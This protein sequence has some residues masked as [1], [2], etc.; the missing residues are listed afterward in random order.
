MSRVIVLN[1]VINFEPEK[2]NFNSRDA[3]VH[4]SAPAAYCFLLLIEKQGELVTHEELYQ[5]AW[6]QFGMEATA[7]TL[8][9]NI[10]VIR[11]GLEKCGLQE[12]IIRT[13][14]R[15]GFIL[16][17]AV[18]VQH[19]RT[20]DLHAQ[21]QIINCFVPP[22]EPIDTSISL[23]NEQ[24][25][26][27]HSTSE[28]EAKSEQVIQLPSSTFLEEETISESNLNSVESIPQTNKELDTKNRVKQE[29]LIF[30][31][32][33]AGSNSSDWVKDFIFKIWVYTAVPV[34]IITFMGFILFINFDTHIGSLNFV[35][36][37]KINQCEYYI[38]KDG[39]NDQRAIE[40]IKR[41][42]KSCPYGKFN[43]MTKYTEGDIV[44]IINCRK[45]MNYIS[46]STCI[47]ELITGINNE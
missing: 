10:S 8:Y 33:Y 27:Q 37:T 41:L 22:S 42:N 12:D 6:R 20:R 46:A 1:D 15:R 7:N 47:S 9:Q 17:P 21:K 13:M 18:N 43:Y 23:I 11:R 24:H 39:E 2:K 30:E 16:S 25:S 45:R 19:T 36:L 26:S 14:P 3:H 44:S 34:A 31:Q 28:A 32:N 38:N 29:K 4:I 5:Y 35:P 40:F